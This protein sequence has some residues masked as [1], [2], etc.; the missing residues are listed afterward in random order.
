MSAVVKFTDFAKYIAGR[1]PSPALAMSKARSD[2]ARQIAACERRGITP[3]A[4]KPPHSPRRSIEGR[5]DHIN[6]RKIAAA[7]RKQLRKEKAIT[8]VN[9]QLNLRILS[10]EVSSLP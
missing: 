1:G 6:P 8:Q 10:I 9:V 2:N 3:G 4:Y 7:E 5:Y